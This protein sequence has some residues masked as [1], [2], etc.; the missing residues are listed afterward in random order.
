M[1]KTKLLILLLG[2]LKKYKEHMVNKK[3]IFIYRDSNDQIIKSL[4][5]AFKPENFQHLTGL[6][7][8]NEDGTIKQRSAQE[9]YNRCIDKP[10]IT[11][12]EISF[13]KQNLRHWRIIPL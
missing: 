8:L 5:V 12:Q 9:F 2:R 3:F 13:E 7:L 6:L 10:Y 1:I 4:E 11:T